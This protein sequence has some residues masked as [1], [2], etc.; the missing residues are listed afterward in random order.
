MKIVN[1]I[2][3]LGNQ[4]FQYAFALSLKDKFPNED[5]LIDTQHF[6]YLFLK[7]YKSCNLHNGYEINKVFKNAS[8]PI[9][10]RKELRLV[11]R[12]IP[13][14]LLSRVARRLLAKK[15]TEYVEEKNYMFYPEVYEFQ[16]SCYYEG[17]WQSVKFHELSKEVIRKEFSFGYPNTYNFKVEEQIA[18]SSS[19]GIHVR[20]GDYLLDPEY[21]G[22]CDLDYYK[23][24]IEK[25][26]VEDKTFFIFS[27]D[28]QWCKDNLLNILSHSS[29]VV[30]V[31]GNKGK[32]SPWDM[33]LMSKC[34]HLIIANSSFSWWGAFLNENVKTVIAPKTW[35][36]RD[37]EIDV[38]MDNW[39]KV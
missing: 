28:I 9:A 11:T 1:V 30:F 27:N 29:D 24:A 5:I 21:K 17:Y 37:Y 4:M 13:N 25:I 2:G 8:L 14:Y 34:E 7:K 15:N 26:G 12:Y 36:N 35:I 19:V 31:D 20:R 39:I 16:G 18:A 3:G 23:R 33:Y 32:D 22:I 38:Y 10:S 6:N